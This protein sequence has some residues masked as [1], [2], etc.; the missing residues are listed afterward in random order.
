MS[1]RAHFGV[2]SSATPLRS[3]RGTV[4]IVALVLAAVI[5]VSLVSYLKV[6]TNS[7]KLAHRSFFSETAN[8]LVEAGLEDALFCFN[9]MG[10]GV[11]V[12]TAWDSSVWTKSSGTA[13][14]TLPTFSLDQNATAVV[15]IY[16]NGY[17][18][19]ISSPII[20]AQATVTPFEGRTIVKYIQVTLKKNQG[21]FASGVVAKNTVDWNGHPMADSWVSNASNSPTGPWAAYPGSGARAKTAVASLNGPVGLGSQGHIEG[22]L[23]L[24]SAASYDN[25]GSYTGTKVNNFTYNFTMPTFPT[26][27][28]VSKSYNLG[29]TVPASL[30]RVLD[31]TA[32]DNRYYYFT[33]NAP[34]SGVTVTGNSSVTIVGS[35]NTRI[36]GNV[37]VPS[38]GSL[39]VYMDGALTGTLINNAWAGA[40]QIYTSTTTG[41]TLNGND[42][43]KC[44]LFAPNAAIT[45]NGGGAPSDNA[46]FSG[47]F[48]GASIRSNGHMQFHYD[49]S[50]GS[51][52]T[53]GKAWTLAEWRELQ[54]ASERATYSSQFN[55]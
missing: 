28:S 33:V 40:L 21:L 23:L 11:A 24:G 37:T 35:A 36:S 30:P 8:H 5:G 7:L 14:R 13:K 29:A 19:S 32:S 48:V 4:L 46:D 45:G 51:I 17:D 27:T 16:V 12:D 26:T 52:G 49:E 39:I 31:E 55:F 20:V 1:T 50:L 6:S 44:A 42:H 47:A 10:S 3:K 22:N 9:Q 34:I 38:T 25:T 53:S 15:K 2:N 41:I 43:M 54:S 18:G